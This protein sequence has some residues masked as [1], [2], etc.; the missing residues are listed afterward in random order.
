MWHDTAIKVTNRGQAQANN[1]QEMQS[2]L[3]KDLETKIYCIMYVYVFF[4]SDKNE[5][6]SIGT[7]SV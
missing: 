6:F 5:I 3:F 1:I 2:N 4:S 7:E